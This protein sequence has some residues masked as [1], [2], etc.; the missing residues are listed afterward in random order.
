MKKLR[1]LTISKRKQKAKSSY[2]KNILCP[3][4]VFKRFIGKEISQQ[5]GQNLSILVLKMESLTFITS[6]FKKDFFSN[7]LRLRNKNIPVSGPML[8]YAALEIK[9]KLKIDRIF[10]VHFSKI[11]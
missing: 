10:K 2:Q 3:D 5:A 8:Q 7:F 4:L 9:E 1:S 6:F 11:N